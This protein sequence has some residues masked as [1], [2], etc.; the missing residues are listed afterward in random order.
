MK[1]IYKTEGRFFKQIR[2]V[3][4]GLRNYALWQ[5]VVRFLF[6]W[7]PWGSRFWLDDYGFEPVNR[8][9]KRQKA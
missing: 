9:A 4:Q 8:S 7:I 5:P 6:F 3:G 2:P 1:P